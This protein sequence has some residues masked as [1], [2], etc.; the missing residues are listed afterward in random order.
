MPITPKKNVQVSHLISVHFISLLEKSSGYGQNFS[1][2]DDNW[3][4]EKQIFQEIT[5]VICLVDMLSGL[6]EDSA[7][8]C[9]NHLSGL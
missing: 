2:I 3:T 9:F 6:A 1:H 7:F 8:G 4:L 5:D